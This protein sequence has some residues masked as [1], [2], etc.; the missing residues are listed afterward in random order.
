MNK[1]E[2]CRLAL[3]AVEALEA[4]CGAEGP[5]SDEAPV[6]ACELLQRLVELQ[7]PDKV[8]RRAIAGVLEYALASDTEAGAWAACCVVRA[9]KRTP[10]H[11]AARVLLQR[12][13]HAH[14]PRLLAHLVRAR[15]VTL[16][17]VAAW[18]DAGHHHPLLLEVVQEMHA[19]LDGERMRRALDDSKIDLGAYAAEHAAG[20]PEEGGGA[21][22]GGDACERALSALEA[23]GLAPLVPQL[24]VQ[25]A[26]ARELAGEPAPQALYRWIKAHV[27]PAVRASPTF[28]SALVGLVAAHVT[29]A[30]HTHVPA[31]DKAAL[32]R[33]KALLEAYAPLLTALL[34]HRPDLQLAAVYAAQ[35][36]AHHHRYPK[37]EY[38]SLDITTWMQVSK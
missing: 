2:A 4:A 9:I 38:F 12:H 15:L 11:E 7:L 24:R 18:C 5:P 34:Q 27:E 23:R 33:E 8:L 32:E 19:A 13:G 26:L 25:A 35:L 37:G 21:A 20:K 6:P 31:P 10:Q 14:L 29:R 16:A 36:H 1:E 28:V 3:S 30:C 17:D 22:G